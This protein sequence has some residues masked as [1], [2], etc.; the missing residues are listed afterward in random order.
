MKNIQIKINQTKINEL[1][2]KLKKEIM[3]SKEVTK[4]LKTLNKLLGNVV[5]NPKEE[6]YHRV[7]LA[8]PKIEKMIGQYKPAVRILQMAGF[9]LITNLDNG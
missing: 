5:K 9:N 8:N 2:E 1:V 3:I 4:T 7:N 6:K